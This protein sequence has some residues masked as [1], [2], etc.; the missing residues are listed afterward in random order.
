MLKLL[1]LFKAYARAKRSIA[2]L[3]YSTGKGVI[4]FVLDAKA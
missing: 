1:L 2:K 4:N 3:T